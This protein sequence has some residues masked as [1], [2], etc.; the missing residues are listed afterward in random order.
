[1]AW[2]LYAPYVRHVTG[3]GLQEESPVRLGV[4]D[5]SGIRL[6][7]ITGRGEIRLTADERKA[8]AAYVKQGGTVLVDA[9][10]GSRAFADSA[11][12]ELEAVF[13]K[14]QPLDDEANLA[15]GRFVG[16]EDISTGVG[17]TLPA[18]KLLRGEGAETRGQKLLVATSDKRPAV[19]YSRFDLC[20]SMAGIA[21]YRSLAYKPDS[22]GRS[23]A[24]CWHT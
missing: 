11:R 20:S 2:T 5:L 23:S 12:R 22:A 3:C 4:D 8:L 7:H 24:T 14:L 19:I 15:S 10:A 17:F 16:G 13:G 6:L 1:M 9:Y 21:N 18:R